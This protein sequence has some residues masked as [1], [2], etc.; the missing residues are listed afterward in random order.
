ML[1][2]DKNPGSI[3]AIIEEFHCSPQHLQTT[4]S[5]FVVLIVD[6]SATTS[7]KYYQP[8]ISITLPN[9]ATIH[10][11]FITHLL[12]NQIAQQPSSIA[13]SQKKK[14]RK[15]RR[16]YGVNQTRRKPYVTG[17]A[18]RYGQW[19]RG[20]RGLC[21]HQCTRSGNETNSR[22]DRSIAFDSRCSTTLVA[23]GKVTPHQPHR[24]LR[25][26]GLEADVVFQTLPTAKL[27]RWLSTLR[28]RSIETG[29]PTPPSPYW[30]C[31]VLRP[32]RPLALFLL[33]KA[34]V[35]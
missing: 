15:L 3:G 23:S 21:A 26:L 24:F 28:M 34:T 4:F 27:G 19:K 11:R 32:L 33:Q 9:R 20:E 14:K 8:H 6:S 5:G 18:K 17:R 1:L 25:P 13:L 29:L 22:F 7:T 12:T 2:S 16:H 35:G 30:P 31:R 10:F